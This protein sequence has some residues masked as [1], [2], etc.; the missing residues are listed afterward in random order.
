MPFSCAADNLAELAWAKSALSHAD[1]A[2][3]DYLAVVT[4]LPSLSRNNLVD[5]R[6][7]SCHVISIDILALS[8]ANHRHRFVPFESPSSRIE[9]TEV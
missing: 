1:F 8:S 2:K 3:P 7:L 5:E 9:G 6:D 4:R